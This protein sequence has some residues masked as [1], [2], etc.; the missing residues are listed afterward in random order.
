MAKLYELREE[1]KSLLD[2][3][4]DGTEDIP[5]DVLSDT[6]EAVAGEIKEK[7]VSIAVVIK[8]LEADIAA[9]KQ[10]EATLA[11][12]RRTLENKVE[13]LKNYVTDELSAAGIKDIKDDPRAAIG[14]R[15]S[16]TLEITDEDGFVNW[17]RENNKTDFLAVRVSPVKANIKKAIEGGETDIP[18]ATITEKKSI[19]IK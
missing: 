8:G 10:E 7:A 9:F 5:E 18:F 19:N 16:R 3:L 15:P 14:F 1:Y 12:R 13:W 2:M 11:K 6:L 4:E 17:A